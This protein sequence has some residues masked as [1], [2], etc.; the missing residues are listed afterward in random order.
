MP[1]ARLVAPAEYSLTVSNGHGSGVFP[2][3]QTVHVWAA[4]RPQDQ[5]V[6]GWTGDTSLL[7]EPQE[8]HSSLV[9][10]HRAVALAATIV[11]RPT[12][13]ATTSFTGSTSRAKTVHSSIPP[14]PR[15]LILFLHGTGGSHQFI[16]GT[17]TF[18]LVLRAL[19]SGY[20]VLGTEAE[21]SVAGDLDGDGKERWDASLSPGNLDFANLDALLAEL[22]ATGAISPTTPLFALGMSNGGATSVSLGAVGAAG[23]AASFPTLRFRGVVSHCA[24][25]R[26]SAVAITTTPTAFLLCA[27]DDN[28]NVDN[29]AAI[30]NAATL[31]SRGIPTLLD[32]HPASPLYDARFA[33]EATIPLATS[34]ALAGEIRAAGF[35]D[36]A[37]FF[38]LPTS[39]MIAA[40]TAN[41]AL[42]PVLTG[43]PPASQGDVVDQIRAMQ[44]EHQMYSDWAAR[45]IAFFDAHNP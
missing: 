17:E 13:L 31:T 27:N 30:A 1:Q 25:G 16:L 26:T 2:V 12:T 33:R 42:T 37:G 7:R 5:L 32:L 14:S 4:A 28:G 45:A 8:W 3:G 34:A 21:E 10:P 6:T 23:V 40:I 43:L 41:P 38:A 19:E 35:V 36:P 22:R 15:G 18:P 39:A 24:S 9:M 44:A 20:G 11:D 29:D